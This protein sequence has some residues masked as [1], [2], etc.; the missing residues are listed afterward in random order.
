MNNLYCISGFGADERVFS[1]LNF[2]DNNVHFIPWLL[3]EKKESISEYARRMAEKIHHENPV[4]L[5]RSFGGM[6]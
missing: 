1:R 2:G 4:L 6:M 3:P 5:G